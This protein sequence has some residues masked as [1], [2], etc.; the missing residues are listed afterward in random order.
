MVPLRDGIDRDPTPWSRHRHC[1]GERWFSPAARSIV[2]IRLGLQTLERGMVSMAVMELRQALVAVDKENMSVSRQLCVAPDADNP[3]ERLGR[4]QVK[5]QRPGRIGC[6]RGPPAD[7][8]GTSALNNYRPEKAPS[9]KTSQ[10]LIGAVH[11]LRVF[12]CILEQ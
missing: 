11:V 7:V 8:L 2:L 12:G 6:H 5:S 4:N 1:G 3:H 10:S 9:A